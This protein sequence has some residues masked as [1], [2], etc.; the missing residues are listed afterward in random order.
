M[1]VQM[2]SREEYLGHALQLAIREAEKDLHWA[3][4]NRWLGWGDYE[5]DAA[6][7]LR[8]LYRIRR[9]GDTRYA[10]EQG[11]LGRAYF[12]RLEAARWTETEK[13]L[14]AGDR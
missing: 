2:A 14:M 5:R 3:R 7:R 13:R 1:T 8:S 9:D 12:D 11:R 6:L 4:E 10:A